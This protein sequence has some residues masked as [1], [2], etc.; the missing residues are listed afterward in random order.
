[1]INAV[2]HSLDPLLRTTCP[3]TRLLGKPSAALYQKSLSTFLRILIPT[4]KVLHTGRD[5]MHIFVPF[6]DGPG[7]ATLLALTATLP[8]GRRTLL[9]D[10]VSDKFL[11]TVLDEKGIR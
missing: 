10:E 5:L 2:S 9:L 4:T 11:W 7:C 6:V 3:D 1:M 8:L